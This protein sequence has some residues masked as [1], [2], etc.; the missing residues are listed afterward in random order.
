MV[1]PVRG[2]R[3]A[4]VALGRLAE[5]ALL[6]SL[7][8]VA[9]AGAQP[10]SPSGEGPGVLVIESAES[11]RPAARVYLDGFRRTLAAD[12]RPSVP[13]YVEAPDLV[14]F[15]TAEQERLFLDYLRN[16]YR[17][18]PIGTILALGDPAAELVLDWDSTPWP[19][20]PVVAVVVDPRVAA[21]VRNRTG[22]TGFRIRFDVGETLDVARAL[23]PGTQRL[24]FVSGA[25]PYAALVLAA[26]AERPELEV[27]RLQ[28]L[29]L[30]ETLRRLATL[31][32]DTF[33]LYGGISADGTGRRFTPRELLKQL[34]PASSRPIFSY[35]ETYLGHGI[36][37]GS[38]VDLDEVGVEA[39][40]LVERMLSGESPESRPMFEADTNRLLFDG[41]QID[42]WGLS[43]DRLPPGSRVLFRQSTLWQEHRGAIITTLLVLLLQTVLIGALVLEA[44]RRRHAQ[45]QLRELNARFLTAEERERGRIAQELHD[46]VTQR[47]ALFTIHLDRIG[48]GE[49]RAPERLREEAVRLSEEARVL[50]TDVQRIARELHPAILDQLG[51]VAALDRHMGGVCSRHTHLQGEVKVADWPDEIPRDLEHVLYRVAQ[52]ALRNVAKHGGATEAGVELR[53]TA[54]ELTLTVSDSGR[55]FDRESPRGGLGLLGMRERVRHVGGR[56]TVDSSPKRGTVVTAAIPLEVVELMGLDERLGRSR[57]GLPEA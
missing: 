43:D 47:L 50:A 25:D 20:V 52:E 24:A 13:V 5:G 45:M 39:A 46:D 57:S 34:V 17:G 11:T 28:D 12:I 7:A 30:E 33:V 56:L 6:G 51:L 23:L 19:D 37:G 55:G 4:R 32:P 42:R 29:P 1:G 38:M 14:R 3:R 41:R 26:V 48:A 54:E 22:A 31:P 9:A 16:R 10:Q 49:K 2:W 8:L 36:V 18:C 21:R 27:I 53:G 40:R 35:A 44:R 15:G